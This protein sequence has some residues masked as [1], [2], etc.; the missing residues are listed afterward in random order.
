MADQVPAPPPSALTPD[1]TLGDLT[2]CDPAP[3]ERITFAEGCVCYALR[4]AARAATQAF[5]DRMR[6]S[7]LR[8]T[9]LSLLAAISNFGP[10]TMRHLAE[11]LGM[12]RTTLNRN[13]APLLRDGLIAMTPGADRRQRMIAITGT[14][15]AR[16]LAAIPLWRRAQDD[17]VGRVGTDQWRAMRGML[18]QLCEPDDASRQPGDGVTE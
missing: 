6:P 15:H 12:D 4:R 7:G 9:Q 10:I 8:V 17:I 11:R 1:P 5:D 2:L 3:P 13:L 16:A 14:G 18:R